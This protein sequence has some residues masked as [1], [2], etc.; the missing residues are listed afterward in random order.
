MLHAV[1]WRPV[2]PPQ[3]QDHAN[4]PQKGTCSAAH[5]QAAYLP[6]RKTRIQLFCTPTR[7]HRPMPKTN[8]SV[9]MLRARLAPPSVFGCFG[10]EFAA[11]SPSPIG[12]VSRR[13]PVLQHDHE[14]SDVAQ[15][16]CRVS[17]SPAT[18][19]LVSPVR[20]VHQASHARVHRTYA[21]HTRDIHGPR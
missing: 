3:A 10:D 15:S 13:S 20:R 11:I 21:G 12:I 14:R 17:T 8:G 19:S 7:A 9:R 16:L 4:E 5:E 6:P 2:V 18:S 1:C